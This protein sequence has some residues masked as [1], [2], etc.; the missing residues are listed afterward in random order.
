MVCPECGKQLKDSATFCKYCGNRVQRNRLDSSHRNQS[1]VIF[2]QDM[3]DIGGKPDVRGALRHHTSSVDEDMIRRRERLAAR[4]K[5]Y[6]T[7]SRHNSRKSSNRGGRGGRGW[8]IPALA[9]VM[10][11]IV[12]MTTTVFLIKSGQD[13]SD[14]GKYDVSEVQAEMSAPSE[15]GTENDIEE[16]SIV[17]TEYE[18]ESSF[19]DYKKGDVITFGKYEQD[20]D[21]SNGAEPIE[22]EV[23]DSDADEILVISKYILDVIPYDTEKNDT[24]WET[25]TLR[26]WLNNEFYNTAFSSSEQD[27]IKISELNNADNHFKIKGAND[28]KDRIFLLNIDEIF[29]LFEINYFD[30][31]DSWGFGES[32]LSEGSFYAIDKDLQYRVLDDSKLEFVNEELYSHSS[33]LYSDS[34][35]G[36]SYGAWWLRSV[37]GYSDIIW[38]VDCDGRFGPDYDCSAEDE[39]IGVRPALR[40]DLKNG[41]MMEE[42]KNTESS[43]DI[44]NNENEIDAIE[45]ASDESENEGVEKDYKIIK[46]FDITGKWKNVGD[47]TYGQVQCGAV[48][49]FDGIYCNVYSPRDTYAFYEDG[50]DYMLECTGLLSSSPVKFTVKIVDKNNI[51]LYHGS[52]DLELTRVE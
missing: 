15:L 14:E 42:A 47:S 7:V 12:A 29:N 48:V 39:D 6:H 5:T 45:S 50:D 9:G 26:N 11:F 46:N 17:K 30:T 13:D 18:K 1:T 23:L 40:I 25:C 52:K 36:S 49:A 20:K 33:Q 51:D 22:W 19:P 3:T 4:E 38:I 21:T 43:T 41:Y 35:R 24:T 31:E 16:E 37:G 8:I 32:L 10:V 27:K 34:S 44:I 2:E 28:T